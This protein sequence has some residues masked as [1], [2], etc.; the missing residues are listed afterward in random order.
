MS[1]QYEVTI[2][3]LVKTPNDED[4]VARQVESLFGFGTVSE[5]FV[6]GLKLREG[7]RFLGVD[8]STRP[9]PRRSVR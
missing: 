7:P 8:V 2:R 4:R 3:L 9:T 6:E 5:S 1:M